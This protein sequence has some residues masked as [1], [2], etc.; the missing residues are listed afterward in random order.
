MRRLTALLKSTG[1]PWAALVV[2][3][4]I[5]CI[6]NEHFRSVQNL[7]N[8]TRQVSYSGLIALGMTFVIA[9]GGID[10]SV[11]SL[12]AF[13]G[14][15]SILGMNAVPG[16]EGLAVALAAVIAIALGAACGAANGALVALGKVPPFIAT[17]GTLVIFRS[18]ALYFG[19]SGLVSSENNVY[20]EFGGAV[21]GGIPLPV[22]ILLILT[23]LFSVI[24]KQSNSTPI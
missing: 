20:R 8:I 23:V 6:S 21:I 11:G 17:L 10:L 15:I 9:G 22:W 19:N 13:S 4:L 18:L 5:C 3:L 14:V 7:V 12:L 1:G 16:S 24:L 2:L